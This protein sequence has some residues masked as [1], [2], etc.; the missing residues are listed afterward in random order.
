LRVNYAVLYLGDEPQQISGVDVLPW[1]QGL[2]A[3][4]L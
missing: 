3:M 1:Q 4:G 2:K